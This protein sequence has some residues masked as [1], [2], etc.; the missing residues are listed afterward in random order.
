MFV[1][2]DSLVV[3]D[4]THDNLPVKISGW[5][6]EVIMSILVPYPQTLLDGCKKA[7]SITIHLE[8]TPLVNATDKAINSNI[9]KMLA[10]MYSDNP[11]YIAKDKV[12]TTAERKN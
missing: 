5:I 7:I 4:Q 12:T 3:L 6:E 1:V 9:P 2:P 8:I 11:R 10:K